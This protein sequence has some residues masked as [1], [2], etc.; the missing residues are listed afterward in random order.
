MGFP[1]NRASRQ[2]LNMVLFTRDR[3]APQGVSVTIMAFA[4][5][6]HSFRRPIPLT[7][8]FSMALTLWLFDHSPPLAGLCDAGPNAGLNKLTVHLIQQ[9]HHCANRKE[10]ALDR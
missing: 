6:D 5:P 3:P 8:H 9:S 1:A 4:N 10:I 2:S 7:H